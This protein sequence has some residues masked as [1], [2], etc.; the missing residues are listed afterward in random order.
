MNFITH[1]KGG[2]MY[3]AIRKDDENS[4]ILV[5]RTFPLDHPAHTE[6][7]IFQI[8]DNLP[9]DEARQLARNK[10]Q[11]MINNSNTPTTQLYG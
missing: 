4:M 10:R 3:I 11:E 6:Y 1:T 2:S 8:D 9:I 7:F 5:D